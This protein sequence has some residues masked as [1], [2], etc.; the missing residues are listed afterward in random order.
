MST[1]LTCWDSM[2][3]YRTERVPFVVLMN[4]ATKVMYQPSTR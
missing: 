4:S 2:I 1:L 3:P